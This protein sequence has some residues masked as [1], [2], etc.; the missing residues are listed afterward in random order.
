MSSDAAAVTP[1]KKSFSEKMLDGIEKAGNKVPHPVIMFL[2]L[3]LGV[4]VLSLVLSWFNISVTEDVAVPIP[5]AQLELIRDQLG[6]IEQLERRSIGPMQVLAY[7]QQRLLSCQVVRVLPDGT[8]VSARIVE[9][10]AYLGVEDRAAH[11]FGGR[12]TARVE[13]M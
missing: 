3:I 10:E 13:P 9:T 6:E 4:M 1:T 2:Y 12:R 7:D 5:K 8:R 11:S